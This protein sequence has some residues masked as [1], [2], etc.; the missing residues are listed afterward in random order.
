[1]DK[2]ASMACVSSARGL[3]RRADLHWDVMSNVLSSNAAARL[4]DVL[5]PA[6]GRLGRVLAGA[7]RAVPSAG[8]CS[9]VTRHAE[10]EW[11]KRGETLNAVAA[12]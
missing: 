8:N 12:Y 1:M 4:L 5:R 7:D 10:S 2:A 11:A 3:R 6:R 9:S